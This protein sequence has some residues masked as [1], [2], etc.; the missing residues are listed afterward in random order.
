[1]ISAEL[2]TLSAPLEFS[3]QYLKIFL[4]IKP[5]MMRSFQK[6]VRPVKKVRKI[7][8]EIQNLFMLCVRV[9]AGREDRTGS[10]TYQRYAGTE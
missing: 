4:Q 9:L 1:L 6:R 2:F 5:K 8:N 3:K 10:T 7:K